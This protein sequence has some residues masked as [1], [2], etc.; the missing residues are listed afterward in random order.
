MI[1][2][3]GSA[4]GVFEKKASKAAPKTLKLQRNPLMQH[5][6]PWADYSPKQKRYNGLSTGNSILDRNCTTRGRDLSNSQESS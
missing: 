4:K 2:D 3:N 6:I 1:S 5:P